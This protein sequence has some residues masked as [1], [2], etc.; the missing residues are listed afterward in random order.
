MPK[1]R[2]KIIWQLL[3]NYRWLTDQEGDSEM[4]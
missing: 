1:G 4:S 3:V 2:T